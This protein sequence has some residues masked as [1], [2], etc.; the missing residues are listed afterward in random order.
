MIFMK[1]KRLL[2]L[3]I[4]FSLLFVTLSCSN[5]KEDSGNADIEVMSYNEHSM[6]SGLFGFVFSY[7]KTNY[8]QL[9]AE[10][11]GTDYIEDTETFWDTLA[12]DNVT[13][14]DSVKQDIIDHCKMVLISSSMAAE[15]GVSL[16][17]DDIE[18]ANNELNDIISIFGSEKKLNNHLKKY[19]I[20][21]DDVLEY[22]KKKYL[23]IALQ[24]KLS[25]EGGLCE[26]VDDDIWDYV[27]Q[28]YIKVKHVYFD[29]AEHDGK[30]HEE[31]QELCNALNSGEKK[32][33]D[34]AELS[35]DTFISS[36]PDGALVG[37]DT[38]NDEYR[39]CAESLEVGKYAVV[40]IDSGAYLITVLDI[41]ED[42]IEEN[43]EALYSDVSDIKFSDL[44]STYYDSVE[45][46]S[47]EISKYDIVTAEIFVK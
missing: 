19:G 11:N 21:A 9:L 26:I 40:K 7:N 42:D 34:I 29:D 30:A 22:L 17:D 24:D 43:F 4:S 15:Y 46:N 13:F 31:L 5:E 25:S 33:D 37:I 12:E 27:K 36:N 3:L 47:T 41:T 38:L 32:F 23:I 10:Y 16:S 1:I 6:S 20:N 39:K 35:E 2:L 8:L 18:M 44:I 28:T 45:I 14:G